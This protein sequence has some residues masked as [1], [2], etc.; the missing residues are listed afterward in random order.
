MSNKFWKSFSIVLHV[1]FDEIEIQQKVFTEA[2]ANSGDVEIVIMLLE[3]TEIDVSAVNNCAI[4]MASRNGH[5]AVV[6]RLLQDHRVKK[7]DTTI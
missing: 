6:N 3:Y 1:L 5:I 4:R 7:L 2:Y